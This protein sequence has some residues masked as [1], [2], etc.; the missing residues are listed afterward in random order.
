MLGKQ[1]QFP[2]IQVLSPAAC[3]M[4][5]CGGLPTVSAEK[6]CCDEELKGHARGQ[7]TADRLW[8]EEP[9]RR[10]WARYGTS[11]LGIM[12]WLLVLWPCLATHL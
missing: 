12:L 3:I 1:C 7:S 2:Y 11:G 8:K 9:T 4:S 10:K 5:L 6:S